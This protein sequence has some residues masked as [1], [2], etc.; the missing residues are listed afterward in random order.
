[1]GKWIILRCDSQ[2][3]RTLNLL[4][5]MR[6]GAAANGGLL[7][8]LLATVSFGT[9]PNAALHYFQPHSHG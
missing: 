7:S 4:H 3:T 8:A 9:R 5:M 2:I 6:G 1:V